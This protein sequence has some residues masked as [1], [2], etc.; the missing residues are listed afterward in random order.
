MDQTCPYSRQFLTLLANCYMLHVQSI[1][2]VGKRVVVCTMVETNGE[3]A[4]YFILSQTVRNS[5]G[6]VMAT[7]PVYE[8]ENWPAAAGAVVQVLCSVYC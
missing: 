4:L 5:F 3:N 7:D 2:I 8:G 1:N 6:S